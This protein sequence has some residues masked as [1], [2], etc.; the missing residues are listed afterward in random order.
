MQKGFSSIIIALIGLIILVGVSGGGYILYQQQKLKSITDY[1]SCSKHYPVLL[2]YPGQCNTPDGRHFIQ[3]L[4]D[5]EKKKLIPPN[6][7]SPKETLKKEVN[8]EPLLYPKVIWSAT[9]SALL[10][11]HNEEEVIEIRGYRNI[12]NLSQG[13]SRE[14]HSDFFD[15]YDRELLQRGWLVDDW[16]MA[17][18]ADGGVR[19]YKKENRR[20]RF[21]YQGSR[22]DSEQKGSRLTVEYSN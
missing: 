1:E 18:G 20:F 11:F 17:D 10:L 21:G 2:S 19:G 4:S 16:E 6:V 8:D 22:G 13:Y 5:E 7:I 14:L 9:E 12:S 3:Q 15:Y